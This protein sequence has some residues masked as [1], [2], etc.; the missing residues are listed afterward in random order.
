MN[1]LTKMMNKL[2]K[3]MNKLT[4]MKNIVTNRIISIVKDTLVKV[5]IWYDYGDR[6]VVYRHLKQY[7][8]YGK[9]FLNV[10]SKKW[11]FQRSKTKHKIIEN[12]MYQK[13]LDEETIYRKKFDCFFKDN[14]EL[15]LEFIGIIYEDFRVFLEKFKEDPNKNLFT[16]WSNHA[17]QYY[18]C[19]QDFVIDVLIKVFKKSYKKQGEKEIKEETVYPYTYTYIKQREKYCVEMWKKHNENDWEFHLEEAWYEY[20]DKNIGYKYTRKW[21]DLYKQHWF[22]FYR[23]IYNLIK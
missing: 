20:Y 2:T 12:I 13:S 18:Y 15:H 7:Y 21:D 17:N 5:K 3:I 8:I 11:V 23:K 16:Q 9:F 4:K 14:L 1:K 10:Y 6:P 19:K 22:N